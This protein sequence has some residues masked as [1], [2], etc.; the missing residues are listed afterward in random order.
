MRNG[1]KMIPLESINDEL[2]SKVLHEKKWRL[3]RNPDGTFYVSTSFG[4]SFGYPASTPFRDAVLQCMHNEIQHNP[5]VELL[6]QDRLQL[7]E[8]IKILQSQV[9]GFT[10]HGTDRER[11]LHYILHM[12]SYAATYWQHPTSGRWFGNE[13]GFTE[14][15]HYV[16]NADVKPGDLV[17]GLMGEV[18]LL[19]AIEPD[20]NWGQA[21]IIQP[22]GREK[23]VRYV[24][25]GFKRIH[26]IPE[27]MLYIGARAEF[28]VL[29]QKMTKLEAYNWTATMNI[30]CNVQ[31]R[32]DQARITI[33]SRYG[34]LKGFLPYEIVLENWQQLTTPEALGEAL[35]AQGWGT[36]E[37]LQDPPL[38]LLNE[39]LQHA[40]P[41]NTIDC[42]APERKD[43][44]EA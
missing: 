41:E 27:S 17:I 26:G 13:V 35:T 36:R 16:S 9:D 4:N 24:N 31:I 28:L 18:G 33:R 19:E 29:M 11:I 20:E 25:E 39:A 30:P 5:E 43:N 22:V 38:S 2:L 23:L 6:K 34:E 8:L 3:W 10:Q 37:F 32:G 15:R 12:L 42:K 21:F 1:E 14:P 40:T 44:G 7:L